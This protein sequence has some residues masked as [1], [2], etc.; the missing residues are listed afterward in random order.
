ML[1]RSDSAP[2][3][4]PASLPSRSSWSSAFRR[5]ACARWRCSASAM[6][7]EGSPGAVSTAFL[8]RDSASS[9]SLSADNCSPSM[10]KA[11]TSVSSR[12]IRA[13]R[14]MPARFLSPAATARAA[15]RCAGLRVEAVNGLLFGFFG[16]LRLAEL[17]QGGAEQAQ[18]RRV[19]R[20]GCR[21]IAGP[22][23]SPR[24]GRR[25]ATA[26]PA[27]APHWGR[28]LSTVSRSLR[29]VRPCSRGAR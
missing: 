2:T 10:T 25:R 13:S 18:G 26:A 4:L 1:A 15:S 3:D 23:V 16:L 20:D 7:A 29:S 6:R 17:A 22:G 9:Y 14:I 28:Q 12:L 21:A 27:S 24:Q 19:R 8:R 11:T 5:I